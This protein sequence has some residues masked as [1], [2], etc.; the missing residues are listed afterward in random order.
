MS[1]LE[2]HVRHE[3][4]PTP[5]LMQSLKLPKF[6]SYNVVQEPREAI[7]SISDTERYEKDPVK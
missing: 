6:Q 2:S 5:P 4:S 7:L 3:G 1:G